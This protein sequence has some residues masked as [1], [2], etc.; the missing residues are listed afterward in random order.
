MARARK[1]LHKP[2]RKDSI[3][4]TQKLLKENNLILKKLKN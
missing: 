3:I 2:R 4:K 1:K